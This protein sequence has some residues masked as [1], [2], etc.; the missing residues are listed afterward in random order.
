MNKIIIKM[1]EEILIIKLSFEI[2][3]T[4]YKNC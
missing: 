4:I 1:Y 3:Q 2:I